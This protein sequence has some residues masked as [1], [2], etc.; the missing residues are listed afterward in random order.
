MVA[1]HVPAEFQIVGKNQVWQ[2]GKIPLQ[3][4]GLFDFI[5][6]LAYVLGFYVANRHGA[7][8]RFAGDDEIGSP[9]FNLL[10]LVG[11]NDSGGQRFNEVFEG[12][13]VSVF[14]GV[15]RLQFFFD[16]LAVCVNWSQSHESLPREGRSNRRNCYH[17][18]DRRAISISNQ[19]RS[20][21]EAGKEP[22]VRAT[23]FVPWRLEVRQKEERPS[24]KR[25]PFLRGPFPA[26][27]QDAL[28]WKSRRVGKRALDVIRRWSCGIMKRTTN[29]S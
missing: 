8:R 3:L 23:L 12:R 1:V 19:M 25:G 13:A 9:T 22:A 27:A 29:P 16:L 7:V 2:G 15:P 20:N 17:R 14:C 28:H 11:G 6:R 26:A 10:R 24:P 18:E 4:V 5:Q 21:K